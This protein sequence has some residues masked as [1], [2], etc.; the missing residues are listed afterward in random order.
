MNKILLTIMF[1]C[2]IYVVIAQL[3]T[4]HQSS[5]KTAIARTVKGIIEQEKKANKCKLTDAEMKGALGYFFK[6]KGITLSSFSVAALSSTKIVD[7]LYMVIKDKKTPQQIYSQLNMS[8]Y[9]ISKE[10]W[11]GYTKR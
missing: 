2:C 10:A 4:D 7:G 11:M 3:T 8:K 1:F 9:G 6:K 5:A